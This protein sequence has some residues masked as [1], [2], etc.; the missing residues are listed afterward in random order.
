MSDATHLYA[1]GLGSNRRHGAHGR[2]SGV[3]S[4]AIARLDADFTLFDASPII[5]NKAIGGAGR[6]FANAIAI[7]ESAL[8]PPL[9]LAELK[10]IEQEFGRRP[11]KRWAERVL[12]LDI[13]L[14][15][16][17][18]WQSK[19][20]RVPHPE[21]AKRAFVLQPLAMIAPDWKVV[22]NITVRH[23]LTRLSRRAPVS[24]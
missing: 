6:D 5:L 15:G 10:A 1:I 19:D 4:A 11:G 17:G 8:P 2:P 13:V 23:L 18:E 12:D 22:G 7:I 24:R 14:W 3:I 21:M 9:I 16:G 20:L